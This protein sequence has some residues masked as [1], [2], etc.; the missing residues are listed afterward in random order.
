MLNRVIL[1][2]RLTQDP[3]LR[4]TNTGTAVATFTLAVDRNRPNQS[5]E[6]E[7]DFIRI[8]VWQKQAELCAQ[9]LH[10]GRLAAVD[11]R[12]QVRSYD[13]RDGQ[14]VWMTEVVAESVRFLDRGDPQNSGNMYGNQQRTPSQDTQ[15]QPDTQ[16]S[17]QFEDDPF[18]DDSQTIDIS[19]DDLPF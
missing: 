19:D 15:R 5:G 3:E 9:Y 8:V 12:L 7:A 14:R 13:N 2:G 18:A 17:P 6:R 4:Y 1:I 16:Q 10:K 11:G